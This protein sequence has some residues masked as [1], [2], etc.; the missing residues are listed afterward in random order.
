[1]AI[2]YSLQSVPR[3]LMVLGDDSL[4]LPGPDAVADDYSERCYAVL[5]NFDAKRIIAHGSV[6][7]ISSFVVRNGV[8]GE[9]A[10]LKDPVKV[11]YRFGYPGGV[12]PE[13]V[14]DRL[15]SMRDETKQW[16]DPAWRIPLAQAAALRYKATMDLDVAME[17]VL[18]IVDDLKIFVSLVSPQAY[19]ERFGDRLKR[20]ITAAPRK[21]SGLLRRYGEAVVKYITV[22]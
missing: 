5:C 21:V 6:S 4:Y 7:F 9:Y 3:F 2:A 19:G 15:Q 16:R 14:S 18:T 22:A 1:M 20:V 11:I 10:L 17:A 12:D 8:T 13:T